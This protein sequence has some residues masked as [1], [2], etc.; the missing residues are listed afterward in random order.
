MELEGNELA[1]LA[2]SFKSGKADKLWLYDSTSSEIV[3]N[4]LKDNINMG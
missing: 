2:L 4:N 3:S 1:D